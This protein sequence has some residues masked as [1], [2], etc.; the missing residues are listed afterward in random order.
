MGGIIG[1]AIGGLIVIGLLVFFLFRVRARRR[2]FSERGISN[3]DYMP[4]SPSILPDSPHSSARWSMVAPGPA[5]A[6]VPA[7]SYLTPMA[8]SASG[9]RAPTLPPLSLAPNMAYANGTRSELFPSMISTSSGRNSASPI[10]PMPTD[11]GDDASFA[12]RPRPHIRET[13]VSTVSVSTVVHGAGKGHSSLSA[14]AILDPFADPAPAPAPSVVVTDASST[15]SVAPSARSSAS[16]IV[17]K[18]VPAMDSTPAAPAPA[19]ADANPFA[20]PQGPPML[21][22]V[23]RLSMLSDLSAD[24]QVSGS[25]LL[26]DECSRC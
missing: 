7:P 25:R 23:Q 3:D 8:A 18:P 6:P 14:D 11:D 19:S 2:A 21:P 10:S 16:S 20:D 15:T 9:A 24:V 5:P 1:G 26:I 22:P 17:R 4:R 13:M 12:A